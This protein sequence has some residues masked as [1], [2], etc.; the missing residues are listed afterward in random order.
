M[1]QEK[2][3]ILFAGGKSHRFGSDKKWALFQGTPLLFWMLDKLKQI[4][5]LEQIFCSADEPI[6]NCPVPA[7]LDEK[8]YQG[9][10]K[11]F[12]TCARLLPFSHLMVVPVDM[13][14]IPVSF[15]RFLIQHSHPDFALVPRWQGK[16]EP[17]IAVYP[18]KFVELFPTDKNAF[19]KWVELLDSHNKV[20]W[21]EEEQIRSYGEPEPIFWNVNLPEDLRKAENW[22]KKKG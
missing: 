5:P 3:I 7:L 13:P 4:T 2:A 6:V 9:P 19:H 1:E 15:L 10:L 22:L 21:V 8:Q 20:Q 16:I 14:L 17:I 12:F 11:A 18:R